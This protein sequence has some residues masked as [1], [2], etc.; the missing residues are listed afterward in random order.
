MRTYDPIEAKLDHALE[1]TFPASDAFAISLPQVAGPRRMP[2]TDERRDEAPEH[3]RAA[4]HDRNESR[5]PVEE[6]G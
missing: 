4:A 5:Q 1:M 3:E 6:H 2:G